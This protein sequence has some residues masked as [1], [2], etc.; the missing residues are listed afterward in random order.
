MQAVDGRHLFFGF[1]HLCTGY[2][3]IT[4]VT[5][6]VELI[7][8]IMQLLQQIFCLCFGLCMQFAVLRNFLIKVDFLF[9]QLACHF[10]LTVRQSSFCLGLTLYRSTLRFIQT[11]FHATLICHL[12]GNS[13]LCLMNLC[14][15][16]TQ[17][18]VQ[19]YNR[20]LYF[21]QHII[22]RCFRHILN[23]FKYSH[24]TFLPSRNE[25]IFGEALQLLFSV[26]FSRYLSSWNQVHFLAVLLLRRRCCHKNGD[27]IE[28]CR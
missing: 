18:L 5:H 17:V 13:Y 10:F 6:F 26:L 22:Y 4:F 25:I 8:H 9:Q 2:K 14:L 11:L 1:C 21:I 12:F 23:P 27:Q 24:F 3:F 28:V 16:I 20:V 7:F 19:H 15:H